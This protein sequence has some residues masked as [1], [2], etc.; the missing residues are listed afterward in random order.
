RTREI[1]LRVALGA[2]PE[3]VLAL[4]TRHSLALTGAGLAIGMA[5]AAFAVRP[6]AMFLMPEVNATGIGN[7]LVV[8][9][10]LCAVALLATLPP[11]F[12]AL[13]VD[14]VVALRHD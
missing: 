3:R 6:L 4:V 2:S 5:L 11:A 1:G 14:P 9:V 13:R 8:G 10:V 12:R 7:F